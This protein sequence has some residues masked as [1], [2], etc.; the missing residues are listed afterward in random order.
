MFRLHRSH[1]IVQSDVPLSPPRAWPLRKK[2]RER[3][4]RKDP[5]RGAQDA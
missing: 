2:H 3:K 4:E 1:V 5:T